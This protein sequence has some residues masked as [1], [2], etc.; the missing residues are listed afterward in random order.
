MPSTVVAQVSDMH[1]SPIDEHDRGTE[2]QPVQDKLPTC[3]AD[4]SDKSLPSFARWRKRLLAAERGDGWLA[5]CIDADRYLAVNQELADALAGELRRLAGDSPVLEICAGTGELARS[6]ATTGVNLEATDV[7]PGDGTNVLRLPAKEALQRFRPTVVLGVFAPFDAGVDEAVLACPSV[8]HY[9]VL[10][11]RIGGVLGSS[12]LW[13]TPGWAAEPL[14]AVQPW[15][16]TRHD[17]GL[18]PCHQTGCTRQPALMQHGEAWLFTRT[19]VVRV[20]RA[21]R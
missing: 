13:Q 12:S 9:V 14:N 11:A 19:S 5:E 4:G 18:G 3:S 1:R 20:E 7:E 21:C 10:N 15:M 8:E 2:P 6:L 17:V 16:L